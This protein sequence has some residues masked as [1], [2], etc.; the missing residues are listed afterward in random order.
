MAYLLATCNQITF[1]LKVPCPSGSIVLV[2]FLMLTL[3]CRNSDS[4]NEV[5][6]KQLRRDTSQKRIDTAFFNFMVKDHVPAASVAIA[7]NGHLVYVRAFGQANLSNGI[8]ADDQSLFRIIE[9]TMAITSLAIK[10][11]IAEGRIHYNSKIFGNGGIL[12]IQN[13]RNHGAWITEVTVENLLKNQSGGWYGADDEVGDMSFRQLFSSKDS[14]ISWV[15][16]HVPL[17][18]PPGAPSNFSLFDYFVLGRIIE[19]VSG[20]SYESYVKE[21]VLLPAGITEMQLAADTPRSHEVAYYKDSEWPHFTDG[22]ID[23]KQY[24]S[25]GDAAL[26]WI[27]SAAD[28]VKLMIKYTNEDSLL[29]NINISRAKSSMGTARADGDYD[30]DWCSTDSSHDWWLQFATLGSSTIM[31]R[32]SRGICWSILINTSTQNLIDDLD[33]IIK[34]I[35]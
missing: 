22:K 8:E 30:F 5:L 15:L 3:S 24:L 9:S 27:A 1:T 25:I 19:K 6:S 13:G 11:L 35:N 12:G 21:R 31:M 20:M 17:K 23:D 16:D 18:S 14:A 10:K 2:I 34:K 4:R 33:Q 7:K 26:G 28:M 29:G 32:S